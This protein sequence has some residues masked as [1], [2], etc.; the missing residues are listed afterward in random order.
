MNEF[1]TERPHEALN[2]QCPAEVYKPSR[3]EYTGLA[4]PSYPFADKTVTV[5]HCGRICLHRKKINLSTVF[6]GQT[7]GIKEVEEHVW[8]VS[9]MRYDLGYIDLEEKTLQPLDN[10]FGPRVSPMS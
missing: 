10:P 3:R 7:V 9:F 8:L 5:T 1:N 2:M 4:E 6:A